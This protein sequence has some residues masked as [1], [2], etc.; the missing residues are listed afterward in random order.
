MF[1]IDRNERL[2]ARLLP[3]IL[4][5]TLIL[6]LLTAMQVDHQ[7]LRYEFAPTPALMLHR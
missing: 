3:L 4:I 7:Q 6:L 1:N 2:V 5:A